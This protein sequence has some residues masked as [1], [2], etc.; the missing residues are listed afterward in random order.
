M[1]ASVAF[2]FPCRDHPK[3]TGLFQSLLSTVSS[4]RNFKKLAAFC[5]RRRAE[6]GGTIPGG[7]AHKRGRTMRRPVR[8][9]RNGGLPRGDRR[10]YAQWV[11]NR[12]CRGSMTASN[13]E[14]CR[15]SLRRLCTRLRGSL[16][17][18]ARESM[19]QR[20]VD[21]IHV[22]NER[23]ARRWRNGTGAGSLGDD[24]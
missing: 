9:H 24:R 7:S 2:A 12:R 3:V 5:S 16:E 13:E 14:V 22:L 18:I 17:G 23:M 21:L 11:R 19:S 20:W 4:L 15:F 8:N 10:A 1:S 6:H